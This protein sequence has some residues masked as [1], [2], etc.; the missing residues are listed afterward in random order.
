MASRVDYE[1][2]IV[3][4]YLAITSIVALMAQATYREYTESALRLMFSEDYSY[5]LVVLTL[6]IYAIY[7]Y[8]KRAGFT[9]EIQLSR[10][11][12]SLLLAVSSIALY[13][14]SKLTVEL[15]LHVRGLSFAAAVVSVLIILFKPANIGEAT[16]FLTPLLTAP[17][18]ANVVDAITIGLSKFLGALVATSTGARLI[19]TGDL[20]L[21]EVETSQGTTPIGVEAACSGIP[22][23]SAVVATI[24]IL[25]HYLASTRENA[26]KKL[27]TSLVALLISLSIGLVGSYVRGA[28]IVLVARCCGVDAAIASLC[29]MP[30]AIYAALSASLAYPLIKRSAGVNAPQAST[31]RKFV[32]FEYMTLTVAIAVAVMML[33]QGLTFMGASGNY[34]RSSIAVGTDAL[35]EVLKN[36]IAHFFSNK[37]EV[38]DSAH[39]VLLTRAM[40]AISLYRVSATVNSTQ[41][42]GFV[43]LVDTP[44][45]LHTLQLCL[46]LQG[47]SVITSWGEL[48]KSLQLG[49]II[50]EKENTKYILLYTLLPVEFKAPGESQAL[51][52]R[53][54]IFKPY[55]GV[56]DLESVR[57]DLLEAISIKISHEAVSPWSNSIGVFSLF[58]VALF[59]SLVLY[60]LMVY[61]YRYIH[62]KGAR[63]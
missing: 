35:S 8:I 62:L 18:P 57:A 37:A 26:L 1:K 19:S 31:S 60:S 28:L 48:Y 16:L 39:D 54:S 61:A 49:Y 52:A 11:L 5:L 34:T 2:G 23:L 4:G 10:L 38:I 41:Y 50:V 46:R 55:R 3:A 53:I 12:V 42:L 22:L 59:I 44:A 24:A 29:Y 47:F 25:P 32:N 21:I 17:I 20:S 7:S 9:S 14:A 58:I 43:E 33:I 6:V 56:Q 63:P 30:S 27:R 13:H 15:S 51:Y 36:P 45:R 40:G